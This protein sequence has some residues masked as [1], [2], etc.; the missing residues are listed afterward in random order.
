MKVTNYC[1]R[2]KYVMSLLEISVIEALN[3][4]YLN[5]KIINNLSYCFIN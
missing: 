3:Y 2:D 4:K 5:V 1:G